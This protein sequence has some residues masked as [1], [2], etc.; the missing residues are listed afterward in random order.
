MARHY[1]A[2]VVVSS[3]EQAG[4]A[5]GALP[6]PDTII[7]ARVG[8]TQSADLQRA[9]DVVRA[10]GGNPLGIV[11]WDA[12]SPALPTPERLA[13]APRPLRTAKMKAITARRAE[14][15]H[16]L[17]RARRAKHH[18]RAGPIRFFTPSSDT[19]CDSSCGRDYQF[20]AVPAL[21]SWS[22]RRRIHSP[23]LGAF[24]DS[25]G[26]MGSRHWRER[27][28]RDRVARCSLPRRF[29]RG[30]GSSVFFG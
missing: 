12:A 18:T 5:A 7:C 8:H 25:D 4:R 20:S 28:R 6:I 3:I 11:L 16:F 22:P 29:W 27:L 2:I 9:L 10:A 19:C 15:Q 30:R 21:R 24:R 23:L 26:R 13:S 1:E 17:A 14:K